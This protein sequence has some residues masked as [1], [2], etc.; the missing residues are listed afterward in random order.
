MKKELIEILACPVCKSPLNLDVKQEIAGDI[1]AG[2][3]QC[4]PCNEIYP[5]DNSIPNLLP[6]R[7]RE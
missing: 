3:L 1:I 7:F 2:S 6:P 4:A 5:I